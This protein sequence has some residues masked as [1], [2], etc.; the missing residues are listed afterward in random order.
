MEKT[1]FCVLIMIKKCGVTLL[2]NLFLP[3]FIHFIHC[4]IENEQ[5]YVFYRFIF[6]RADVFHIGAKA[7]DHQIGQPFF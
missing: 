7:Y 5:T 4:P 6:R 3:G 1:N 2:E